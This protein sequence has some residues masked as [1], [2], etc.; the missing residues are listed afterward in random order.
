MLSPEL[1]RTVDLTNP[2]FALILPGHHIIQKFMVR[3][4]SSVF[5]VFCLLFIILLALKIIW[6]EDECPG[7]PQ[8]FSFDFP[9]SKY[10]N[11]LRQKA[12]YHNRPFV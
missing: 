11:K 9:H 10:E 3:N 2:V 5:F 1:F 7:S 6:E 8:V 12:P 4:R